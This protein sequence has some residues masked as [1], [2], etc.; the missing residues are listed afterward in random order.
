M[1]LTIS[2]LILFSLMLVLIGYQNRYGI[3]FAVMS[4]GIAICALALMVQIRRFS[5][6]TMQ[7]YYFSWIDAN[8][9]SILNRFSPLTLNHVLR[10]E[11]LGV[12]LFLGA[13]TICTYRLGRYEK[14]NISKKSQKFRK[15]FCG[16]A[17]IL[18][19]LYLVFFS[20]EVGFRIFLAQ[21]RLDSFTWG[22][23]RLGI[24][25]LYFILTVFA[26]TSPVIPLIYLVY[27]YRKGYLIIFRRRLLELILLLAGFYVL[28]LVIISQHTINW[29]EMLRTGF[30][31]SL[32]RQPATSQQLFFLPI[33]SL[34]FLAFIIFLFIFF[35]TASF[36]YFRGQ[37]IN[38]NLQVLPDNLR[39]VLH[40]EKNVMFNLKV[41]SEAALESYGSE[42]GKNKLKR[43]IEV[44]ESHMEFLTDGINSIKN[45]RMKVE[46]CDFL[47]TLESALRTYSFP[48][49]IVLEKNLPNH[50][51]LC[52]YD[53]FHL[54][55]V[56]I[57]LLENATAA[58]E[59]G[60]KLE[61]ILETSDDFLMMRV[62]DEGCGIE[63]KHLKNVFKPYFSTKS[64][65][66]NWGL[67]LS[68]VQKVVKAH[69]GFIQITSEFG[70]GTEVQIL[71][72][73]A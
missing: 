30:W 50:P 57:N 68:Y 63:P 8:I 19:F 36:R 18:L 7:M 54:T 56:I 43:L 6:S 60:G 73:R 46:Q 59:E 51:V 32:N 9:F 62:K 41:L 29:E 55:K 21:H 69:Y 14:H 33:I 2:F 17:A 53:P 66:F 47:E 4:L 58:M 15:I 71:M 39:D 22:L 11:N 34:S 16:I 1:I 26:F 12:A 35:K 52:K 67:G 45:T 70:S 42:D 48:D 25:F 65:Q 27:F 28:Y 10:M 38:K 3:L 23:Y 44:G 20:P 5:F 61:V 13:N 37:A 40:S 49:W 64:K 31:L 72:R 24:R